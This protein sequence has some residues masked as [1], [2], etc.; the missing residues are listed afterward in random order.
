MLVVACALIR[1]RGRLL[2]A[3]RR[4]DQHPPLQ[5]EFPGGKVEPGESEA[6]CLIREI[7]EELGMDIR[8]LRR[9]TPVVHDYGD[10]QIQLIPYEC[11]WT[12]GEPEAREH[13][14][15]RWIRPEEVWDY[16][17]CAA[18]VPVVQQLFDNAEK[19]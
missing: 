5:W 10:K 4:A 7:R 1:H 6:A 17:W 16:D 18:D 2:I 14:E 11:E 8:P 13:A 15:I 3:R 12:G 9:L 19:K